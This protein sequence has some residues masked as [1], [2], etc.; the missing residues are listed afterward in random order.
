MQTLTATYDPSDDKLRLYTVSRLSPEDYARAKAVGFSWAPKQELFVAMWSPSAEDLLIEWCGEIGE[1]SSTLEDRAAARAERFEGYSERREADGDR[2]HA[3]VAQLTEAIPLGQPILVG[4]HSERHARRD[5]KRIE[6]GMRRAVKN[7]ETAAYWQ[8]RAQ[9]AIQAADYRD[10]ADVRARRIET[11][12]AERRKRV[13]S[14]T[15]HAQGVGVPWS[16]ECWSAHTRE[17]SCPKCERQPL[18]MVGNKGRA[19]HAVRVSDLPALEAAQARWIAHLDH[20]ITYERELLKAQGAS[21]MLE[22]QPRPKQLPL[23]NYHAP[24]GIEIRNL[25][26]PDRT[27]R[28]AQVS[29]SKAA[30][31]AK[32]GDYKG[33]ATSADGSHRVRVAIVNHARVLVFLSDSATHARPQ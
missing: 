25:Y 18:A 27:E 3:R 19:V 5:A 16:P 8:Q 24:E 30:Y 4:H 32:H 28:L 9:G 17:T 12:E 22:K 20:R 15:P 2:E 21:S 23:L 33:T 7:W 29:M 10:R 1:E 26:Y 13:A 11:L 6:D 14:Y 31:A